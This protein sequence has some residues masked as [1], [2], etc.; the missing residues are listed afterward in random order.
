MNNSL[1]V[2][3]HERGLAFYIDGDLQFDTED[4]AIYHEYLVIPAIALAARRFP[5]DSL[6][7]LICGGGDGLA[8]RDVLRFPQVDRLDLVDYNPEVI[9]YGKTIFKPFNQGSLESEILTIYEQEAFEFISDFIKNIDKELYHVIICDFTYPN[10]LEETKIYSQ[11]WYQKLHDILHPGGLVSING[12]SPTTRTLGFWCLYKTLLSAGLM[13]KPL[14][15][16]IPS[17]QSHEYGTW[18]FF[19]ASDRSILQEEVRSLDP[20]ESGQVFQLNTLLN[21]FI[22]EEAIANVCHHA[23]INTLKF[24]QLFYYLL[25]PQIPPSLLQ[26]KEPQ[27]N[28]NFL[29]LEFS[30]SETIA[31]PIADENLLQLESLAKRWI[32]QLD[33]L[34]TSN[35]FSESSS[36]TLDL[37]LAELFPVQHRYHQPKMAEE[38]VNYLKQLLAEVDL[39]R[40]LSSLLKR[41]QQLPEKVV[42]DLQDLLEKIRSGEPID[43]VSPHIAELVVLLSTTLL[44]ANLVIPDIAFAKGYSSSTEMSNGS[45]RLYDNNYYGEEDYT[46]KIIGFFIALLSG[47]WFYTLFKRSS[48]NN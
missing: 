19:I 38:W 23:R 47:Y 10:R 39:S 30:Q 6:R 33:R 3:Q 8:A 40:L 35:H 34:K 14:Q 13:A 16:D 17:F 45:Y 22:F 12:V 36:E 9:K 18:G 41:S 25:N 43:R 15:I 1:F 31:E 48:D 4:E 7:V 5:G 32:E 29:E 26:V 28:I 2:E 11:E 44:M 27:K 37:N 20:P 24:P 46:V 21:N 42:K